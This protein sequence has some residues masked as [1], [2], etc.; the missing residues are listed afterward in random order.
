MGDRNSIPLTINYSDGDSWFEKV[1]FSNPRIVLEKGNSG[2]WD[3]NG[4]RDPAI[5]VDEDGYLVCED[6]CMIMYYTGSK[7]KN[8]VQAIGRA[9]SKDNGKTWKKEPQAPVFVHSNRGWESTGVGTPWVVKGKDN[10]YRLYYRG[11]RKKYSEEAIGLA[12]S[13]DG[14]HFHRIKP[15]PILTAND[16]KGLDKQGRILLAVTN[17]VR[18]FDGRDL[19]SFEGFDKKGQCQIFAA[20]SKDKENFEPFNGGNPIFVADNVSTWPIKGVG[21]PRVIALEVPKLYILTF[22]GSLHSE[23]SIGQAFSEDLINWKE[24]RRNPLVLPSGIP[25]KYPFSGRIEGGIIPK[26]DL[27]Q[28]INPIRMFFMAIPSHARSHNNG[29][30]GIIEGTIEDERCKAFSEISENK[31]EI[32]MKEEGIK[33]EQEILVVNQDPESEIPPRAVFFTNRKEGFKEISFEFLLKKHAQNGTAMIAV[34][35]EIDSAVQ[36]DGIKIRFCK[37]MVQ[38]KAQQKGRNFIQRVLNK[39]L[40]VYFGLCDWQVWFYCKNVAPVPQ[41]KW[42]HFAIQKT[43]SIYSVFINQKKIGTTKHTMMLGKT[44]CLSVQSNGLEINV[45]SLEKKFEQSEQN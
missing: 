10:I 6:H 26:E 29:V 17:I 32:F 39:I 43:G 45:R 36:K 34:G 30:I 3:E 41:D 7:K 25:V 44:H 14:I 28:K 38:F 2:T 20:V 37:E 24:H 27:T 40:K 19:L 8:E 23:Y 4:I 18:L 13:N 1:K 33:D 5:L 11:Y 31:N 35:E 9:I 12:V 42:N 22:N 16:F 21:N 15:E